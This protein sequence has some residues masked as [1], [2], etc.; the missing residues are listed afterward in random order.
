MFLKN[1]EN[2]FVILFFSCVIFYLFDNELFWKITNT[3]Y[4]TIQSIFSTSN[5]IAISSNKFYDLRYLQ[6]I[7][8]FI[9]NIFLESN[10][11]YNSYK[12]TGTEMVI[13]YPRIWIM[14]GYYLNIQSETV[15]Y[16]TYII[17]F[18]LYSYIFLNFT[19]KYQSY[20]FC[21]LFISGSNLLLLERGNV[22]FIIIVLIFYTYLSKFK[23]LNYI[24]YIL[25]SFLK[26][27][28]AFS[29]LFFLKNKKSIIKI[30]LLS[31]IFLIYLF[32]TKNDIKNI[33][34]VNPITGHSSYGFL[35]IILNLK[36]NLNI[37][38]NYI[39]ITSLNI[40]ILIAIYLKFFINKLSEKNFSNT[41][42]FL[43][44]GGIFI[45]TFLINT[46][47]DYRMMFLIFCVP[48]MLEIK[49]YLLKLFCFST[50]ILS[51]ELQRLLF[52]FGFYGGVINSIAKLALFYVIGILYI[53]LIYNFI[54]NNFIKKLN[55][56]KNKKIFSN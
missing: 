2:L 41:N 52:L 36:E 43:L 29:L 38:L 50:L 19:K 3:P 39:F 30:M 15:L 4:V 33:S 47:H 45:F 28:P 35:S 40:F 34:T 22:D 9:D 5:E 11:L 37:N 48:L 18:L 55:N 54:K 8:G 49:H 53:H 25:V 20:F 24:G 13:N 14:L 31:V 16:S 12:S 21:Y 23:Y 56:I 26:I 27:Y 51:L 10:I 1:K 44:G 42:I 32:I 6:Y 17:F 46:H 7:S